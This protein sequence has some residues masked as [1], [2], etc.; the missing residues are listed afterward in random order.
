MVKSHFTKHI[1]K[2]SGK[3]VYSIPESTPQQ[4][5][6]YMEEGW[7]DEEEQMD[8]KKHSTDSSSV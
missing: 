7:S 6:S 3:L 5:A 4:Q 2:T 8:K 1:E